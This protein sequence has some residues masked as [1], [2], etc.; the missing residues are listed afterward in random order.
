MVR[1]TWGS[2][3]D[4]GRDERRP[5]GDDRWRPPAE[6]P[7]VRL[8]DESRLAEAIRDRGDSREL[9][10]QAAEQATFAGTLRDLAEAG[11]GVVVRSASGRAYHGVILAVTVDHVVVRSGDGTV[12]HLAIDQVTSVQLDPMVRA[13][14]ATGE[15]DAAQDRTLDEVLADAVEVTP[16]VVLVTRGDGELHRG[17]LVA[18]GEDVVSI[19]IEPT[20]ATAYLAVM[21][22]SEV[23]VE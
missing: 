10:R 11:T 2:T 20:G 1:L 3:D 8:A 15:R 18:V 13:G 6:D 21:A 16:M 14:A 9:R 4:E 17:R 5:V 12:V 7:F 19:R 23:V 22:L